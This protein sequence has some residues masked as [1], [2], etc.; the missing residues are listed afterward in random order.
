MCIITIDI[1]TVF[2]IIRD[3]RGCEERRALHRPPA[4]P[5]EAGEAPAWRSCE[6]KQDQTSC[7]LRSPF[8]WTPLV[9]SR[10]GVGAA[11]ALPDCPPARSRAGPR[12]PK[13]T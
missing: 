12:A 3:L 10:S 4:A 2:I 7:Y 5:P 9:P 8:L 11:S 1:S 6:S 13:R